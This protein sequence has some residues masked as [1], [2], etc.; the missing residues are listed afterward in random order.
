MAPDAVG[1][2]SCVAEDPARTILVVED[3]DTIR[4]CVAEYLRDC[5]YRVAEAPDVREAMDLLASQRVGLV[6][7]DINMPGDETG[8]TLE[9]WI[10]RHLPA[11]KVILTSGFPQSEADTEDLLEPMIAKPYSCAALSRRIDSLLDGGNI[12]RGLRGIDGAYDPA[13]RSAA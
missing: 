6:F 1:M 12:V 10:R 11:V 5:G 4:T 7:S 13:C 8:F 3:E 9:K 2:Q